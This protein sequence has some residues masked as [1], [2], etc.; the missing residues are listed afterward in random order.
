M[1]ANLNRLDAAI[2]AAGI[3]IDGVSGSQG[4]VRVDY[5]NAATALQRTQ[6]DAI[7]AAF[8][9]TE[10]ADLTWQAQQAKSQ[11]TTSIDRGALQTGESAERLVRALA[12]VVLDEVNLLRAATVPT[13]P[14]RTSA[15]LI[16]AIKAKIAATA[17]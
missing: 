3:P 5:Q 12:L 2:R 1:I 7:V 11:A 4:S 8:S 16:T 17:E 9:W 14:A 15:Q 10:A 6:G 13:L